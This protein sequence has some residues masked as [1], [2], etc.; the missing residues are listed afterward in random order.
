MEKNEA[1]VYGRRVADL[2]EQAWVDL[3]PRYE[4]TPEL[5]V[6]V[7]IYSRADDF[8]VR[9]FG[10]P[11]VVGFLGVCFGKVI[12]ANSPATRRDHPT[13]WESILWHEFCHVS[14]CRRP[15]TKFR[16]G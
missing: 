8:S 10:M 9:T 14:H 16:A 7:E 6:V 2:L 1:A 12:T 3:T 11:D 5:P 15:A 4:F 13:S